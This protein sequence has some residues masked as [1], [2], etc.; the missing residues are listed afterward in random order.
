MLPTTFPTPDLFLPGQ[1]EPAL[2]WGVLGPG[3]IA[4]AFVDALRRNTRQC[5]FG[6]QPTYV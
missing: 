6:A 5:P 4:P 3:K 2:R 1:G